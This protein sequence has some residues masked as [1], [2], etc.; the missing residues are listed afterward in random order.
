MSALPVDLD[1]EHALARELCRREARL[2]RMFEYRRL[3]RLGE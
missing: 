1:I 3:Q 2:G